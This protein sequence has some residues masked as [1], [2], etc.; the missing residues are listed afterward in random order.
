MTA[1]DTTERA[2]RIGKSHPIYRANDE[3]EQF[4]RIGGIRG[5]SNV[6]KKD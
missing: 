3:V 1:E 2:V 5:M 6:W 4:R